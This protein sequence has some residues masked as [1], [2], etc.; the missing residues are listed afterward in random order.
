MGE[1]HSNSFYT[2]KIL[3]EIWSQLKLTMQNFLI[4]SK[5]AEDEGKK[6]SRPLRM[7]KLYVLGALL[8]EK[9]HEQMKLTSR[10]KG[11]SQNK[12]EV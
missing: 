4:L 8:V 9:Y 7:K 6:K 2:A 1:V 5:I 3:A 11:R 12:G 10:T